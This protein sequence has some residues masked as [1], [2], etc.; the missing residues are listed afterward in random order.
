MRK[1]L[2]NN[3]FAREVNLTPEKIIILWQILLRMEKIGDQAKR[4]AKNLEEAKLSKKDADEIKE[5]YTNL[6]GTYL[7]L[8]NA[9]IKP[10]VFRSSPSSSL[11]D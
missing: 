1:A 10:L 9:Y 5:I 11:Q 6:E 3:L 2:K 4:I 8:M 7:K